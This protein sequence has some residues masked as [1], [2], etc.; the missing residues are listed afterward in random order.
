MLATIN[1][2]RPL[3]LM[4]LSPGLQR[5]LVAR[6]PQS[7]V[8]DAHRA[9]ADPPSSDLD[10]VEVPCYDCYEPVELVYV[11]LEWAVTSPFMDA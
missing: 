6:D 10:P 7:P 9:S 1:A 11:A 5:A 2:R 4:V 3:A 8:E